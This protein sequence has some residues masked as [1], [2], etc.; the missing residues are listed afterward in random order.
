MKTFNNVTMIDN[1][2]T[3]ID[4]SF[5]DWIADP[6]S[7]GA[8]YD[9]KSKELK[10]DWRS[11]KPQYTDINGYYSDFQK[12][13]S[14]DE[15][16]NTVRAKALLSTDFDIDSADLRNTLQSTYQLSHDD[17]TKIFKNLGNSSD[18]ETHQNPFSRKIT[19]R[20]KSL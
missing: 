19:L 8:E 16:K 15:Y 11:T 6:L 2:M 13:Q 4:D 10:K 5:Y 1:T 20:K 9:I 17:V 7:E 3:E 12:F 18:V 14:T